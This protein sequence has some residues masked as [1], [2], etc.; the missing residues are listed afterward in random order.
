[1]N[2]AR[3]G[4]P[5]LCV[6]Y[7]GT[8]EMVQGME[9]VLAGVPQFDPVA[10]CVGP[11]ETAQSP[12][13]ALKVRL[14]ILLRAYRGDYHTD[15][16]EFE[17]LAAQVRSGRE[18]I[19][20]WG[21]KDEIARLR[22]LLREPT[23]EPPD[24]ALGTVTVL[25]AEEEFG[26][27]YGELCRSGSVDPTLGA[28]APIVSRTLNYLN[29][30]ETWLR[31]RYHTLILAPRNRPSTAEVRG[32]E[33]IHRIH[34]H[35]VR[36]CFWGFAPFYVM[37]GGVIEQTEFRESNRD[38][39]EILGALRSTD[40]WVFADAR[41]GA[42]AEAM[43]LLNF[44]VRPPIK[45]VDAAQSASTTPS[46][47]LL[48]PSESLIASNHGTVLL[49]SDGAPHA[50]ALA[51]HVAVERLME[52]G[53][54]CSVVR[55][56]LDDPTLAPFQAWL[57]ARGFRLT[58]VVPPK[59]TWVVRDGLRRDLAFPPLGLWSRPRPDLAVVQPYYLDQE[60]MSPDEAVVLEY[61]RDRLTF[62]SEPGMP[63]RVRAASR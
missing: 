57:F 17:R 19:W 45:I 39:E 31:E 61:V 5:C 30:R 26:L 37:Q 13:V 59:R 4:E 14:R 7:R 63:A 2:S 32:G 43:A 23:A 9:R 41:E 46:R 47:L 42:Y 25:S 33:A 10:N 22:Q 62:T 12:E 34:T 52:S 1:M 18:A 56:R 55:M 54:C 15:S 27:G 6:P 48:P 28:K 35:Y 16:F 36:S 21:H 40:P 44:G 24:L 50:E 20:F 29:G 60:A 58:A 38:P 53:V 11:A 49:S 3:S 51:A 8:D